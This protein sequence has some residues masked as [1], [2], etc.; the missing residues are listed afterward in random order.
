MLDRRSHLE[1]G[2]CFFR[3]EQGRARAA[4]GGR[5]GSGGKKTGSMDYDPST[6]RITFTSGPL[7]KRFEAHAGRRADG[8]P[9]V[10]LVDTDL[11]PKAVACDY[12]ARKKT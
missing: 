9:V 11:A 3:V 12:C 8:A 2:K 5:W 7:G 4:V 1:N 10:I 6:G